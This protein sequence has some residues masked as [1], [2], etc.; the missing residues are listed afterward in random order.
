VVFKVDKPEEIDDILPLIALLIQPLGQI[1][2]TQKAPLSRLLS[3]NMSILGVR[4]RIIQ[5][6]ALQTTFNRKYFAISRT[7]EYEAPTTDFWWSRLVK[8]ASSEKSIAEKALLA[9]AY[10]TSLKEYWLLLSNWLDSELPPI[11]EGSLWISGIYL[12]RHSNRDDNR[13][14]P[15]FRTL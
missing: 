2:L 11:N 9:S 8:S 7:Y 14:L 13:V 15:R 3:I 5:L 10:S 12:R 4:E 6:N 1:E